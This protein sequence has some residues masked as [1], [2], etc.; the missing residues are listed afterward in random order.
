MSLLAS[1][2]RDLKK[3]KSVK[4]YV[5]KASTEALNCDVKKN[6]SIEVLESALNLE[7]LD[8]IREGINNISKDSKSNFYEIFSNCST[9][10][11]EIEGKIAEEQQRIAA[12]NERCRAEA[13]A[14]R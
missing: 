7:N 2:K 6:Q 13:Q 8:V 12:E 3:A 4:T 5:S 1:Y 10:I 9:L 11:S 14:Q